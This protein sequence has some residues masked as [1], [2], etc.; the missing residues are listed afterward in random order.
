MGTFKRIDSSRASQEVARETDRLLLYDRY[1][2]L[3]YGVILQIIPEPEIAQ[4]V[5][6]DLFSSS[7]VLSYTEDSRQV[8]SKIIR[9]ARAK[10]LEARP[11]GFNKSVSIQEAS[12]NDDMG[13]LV[14]DLSFYKGFT[15]EEIA[16]KLQL[17]KTNVLSTIYTYFKQQ[18]SS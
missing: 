8:S 6:I 14:F 9:L 7:Q 15:I 11:D 4:T 16:D 12:V 17:S 1:G 3:A 13:K 10:A 18:R 2:S 5:L